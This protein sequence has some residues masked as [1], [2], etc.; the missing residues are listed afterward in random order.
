ML[1]FE[2]KLLYRSIKGNVP[3]EPYELALGKAAIKRTG[4]DATIVTYGLAVHWALE[5]AEMFAK[6]GIAIEVVD[7]RTLLPWDKPA[8]LESVR[9]TNRVLVLHEATH[10]GGIGGEIAATIAEEAF[11]WLDAPVMRL[12]SQDMPIPFNP[13]LEQKIFWPKERLPEKM[14]QL[15]AY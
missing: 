4:G 3:E 7:L 2:H 12:A 9:K 10:T 15:L 6:E 14:R 11:E 8:V 13:L 5:I 1:F